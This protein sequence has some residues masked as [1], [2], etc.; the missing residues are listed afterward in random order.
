MGQVK[1]HGRI[2]EPG[3]LDPI[4][5]VLTK[6]MKR[7]KWSILS[8]NPC[9]RAI[10]FNEWRSKQ[11]QNRSSNMMRTEA[12]FKIYNGESDND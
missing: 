6:K 8:K 12:L 7:K 2:Y 10:H 11:V 5:V 1:K 9:R 3:K 4:S